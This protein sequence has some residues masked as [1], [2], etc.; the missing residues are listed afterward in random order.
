MET[1][2]EH[3]QEQYQEA[4]PKGGLSAGSIVLL[5][6]IAAVAAVF[7]FALV[8][9][10][11][12]QPLSGQAPDFEFTTFIHDN[13]VFSDDYGEVQ[14]LSDLRGNIVVLNFWASWCTECR[15]EAA[16]LEAAWNKYGDQGVIFLGIAYADNGPRSMQ[17]MEEF[18]ISYLNAPDLGTRISEKYNITGV[19]ETFFID[20]N[21]DIVDFAMG[22]L[23]KRTMENLIESML[24]AQPYEGS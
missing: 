22:T 2:N 1:N 4:K 9:Q 11:E 7:G 20:R 14:K 3:I 23:S 8:K 6:G 15:Y 21:G 17:Y 5:M 19:P 16:E 10:G 24:I 13:Y 18:Q 12:T